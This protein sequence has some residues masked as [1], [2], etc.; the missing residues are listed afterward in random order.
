MYVWLQLLELHTGAASDLQ[1]GSMLNK[2]KPHSR[3]QGRLLAIAWP[4][5]LS[6]FVRGGK[7]KCLTTAYTVPSSSS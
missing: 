7:M 4:T 3:Q 1:T 2:S 5:L 6:F